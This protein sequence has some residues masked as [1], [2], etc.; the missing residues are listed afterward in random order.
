MAADQPLNALLLSEKF[1]A[2][3]ELLEVRESSN[4]RR[5][6]RLR[7]QPNPESPGEEFKRVLSDIK[8]EK[9]SVVRRNLESLSQKIEGV[10]REDGEA[11]MELEAFLKRYVD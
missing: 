5:P 11:R 8:G 2:A 9:G 4:T 1:K 10:W 7:D 3:F 6:Y